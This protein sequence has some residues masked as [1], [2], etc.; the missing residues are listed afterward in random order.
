MMTLST[1]SCLCASNLS[2]YSP[3]HSQRFS[4]PPRFPLVWVLNLPRV[5]GSPRALDL[6]QALDPPQALYPPQAL[7]SPQV[8]HAL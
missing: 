7:E 4:Q 5:L 3:L 2:Y 1:L 8:R 6:P